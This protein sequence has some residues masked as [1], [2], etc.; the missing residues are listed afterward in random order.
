M[1]GPVRS[2]PVNLRTVLDRTALG[3]AAVVASSVVVFA[4][5]WDSVGEGD[6]V[7]RVDERTQHWMVHHRTATDV[8]VARVVTR[9]CDGWVVA[10]VVVVVTLGLWRHRRQ[11]A[12]MLMTSSA[13]A[14][15]LV[16]VAKSD[17]ARRRPPSS[18]AMVRALGFAFPSGHAT[19][20]VA[21]YGALLLLTTRHSPRRAV[22]IAGM[23]GP[24]AIALVVGASR[25]VLG[26]HWFSDVIAGWTLGA[27]WL[28]VVV[29]TGPWVADRWRRVPGAT[30][31]P[32]ITV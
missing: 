19:Q 6:L 21:C 15:I 24:V 10:A 20:S 31:K 8:S 7:V 23:A 28:A 12:V 30:V 27:G 5:L 11:L 17:A 16:A 29:T 14:A 32:A 18:E 26:V 2:V 9:L 13:G 22:R 4:K 1:A 25:I 3:G